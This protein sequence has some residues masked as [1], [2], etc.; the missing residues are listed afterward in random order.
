MAWES[1]I[2]GILSLAFVWSL[3]SEAC[4][5][6]LEE[7]ERERDWVYSESLSVRAVGPRSTQHVSQDTFLASLKSGLMGTSTVCARLTVSMF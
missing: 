6:G 2:L 4:V 7:R 3:R 5:V 1:A